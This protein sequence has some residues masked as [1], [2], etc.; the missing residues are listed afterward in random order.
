MPKLPVVKA[1]KLYKTLQKI[2]AE[3]EI[4]RIMAE[5]FPKPESA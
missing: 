4:A 3:P 1:S 2:I 5:A